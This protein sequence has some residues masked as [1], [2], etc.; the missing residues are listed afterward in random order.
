MN[1]GA[2][3][4]R[5]ARLVYQGAACLIGLLMI[6]S[7]FGI[8]E[9]TYYK[10]W[11]IY[12][13]NLSNYFCVAVLMAEFTETLRKKENRYSTVIPRLKFFGVIMIILTALVFHL[14]LAH[15]AGRDPAKNC[16]LY[17]ILAHT[18]MPLLFVGDWLLFYER[19][20]VKWHYPLQS[21]SVV[22]IYVGYV[23]VRGTFFWNEASGTKQYPYTFLN[24][25]KIGWD[26]V[27]TWCAALTAAFLI[28]GILLYG[29][30]RKAKT[31]KKRKE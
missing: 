17:C 25:V 28:M 12:F 6:V 20:Q 7:S 8:F 31:W 30:D 10:N 1:G 23:L 3:T 18:V 19:G 14:L 29:L 5:T 2:R 21:L 22:L 16:T 24:P 9:N 15:E 26:G 13:T 4:L 27:L 11:F